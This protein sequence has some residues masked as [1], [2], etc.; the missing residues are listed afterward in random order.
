MGEL[1]QSTLKTRP[2]W[3]HLSVSVSAPALHTMA[4]TKQTS[5]LQPRACLCPDTGSQGL[6][7]V[8]ACLEGHWR[9]VCSHTSGVEEKVSACGSGE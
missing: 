6:W 8:P 9:G 1:Q 2:I 3:A 5:K 4:C 7:A